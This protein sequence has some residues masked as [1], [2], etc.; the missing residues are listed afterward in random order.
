MTP[1]EHKVTKQAAE[2]G[3][4]MAKAHCGIC[5]HFTAPNHC[6]VVIGKVGARG[7]CKYFEKAAKA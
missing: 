3:K 7:W 1:P 5:Q 4:G 6:S 2:Y